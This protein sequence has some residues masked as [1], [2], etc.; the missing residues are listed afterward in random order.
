ME[1]IEQAL[2]LLDYQQRLIERLSAEN[3]EL[4]TSLRQWQER[5]LA[6]V[7]RALA[8]P[9]QPPV[10]QEP[11]EPPKRTRK[12]Y[13]DKRTVPGRTV[14]CTRCFVPFVTTPRF[15]SVCHACREKQQK[16]LHLT[17]RQHQSGNGTGESE[18]TNQQ[19]SA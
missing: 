1:K 11:E 13:V 3:V 4:K 17:R 2:Q 9:V 18:S 6:L 5:A 19:G 8:A 15:K 16:T 7:D 12:A 14:P 10:I